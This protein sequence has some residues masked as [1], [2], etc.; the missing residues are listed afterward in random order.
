MNAFQSE[1]LLP[2]NPITLEYLIVPL[3]AALDDK[4]L[5]F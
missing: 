4:Y 3:V 5:T 2:P 1:G